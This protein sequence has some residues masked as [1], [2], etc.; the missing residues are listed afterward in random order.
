MIAAESFSADIEQALP[1]QNEHALAAS[2]PFALLL[3]M[4]KNS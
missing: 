2:D 3:P 1:E 4:P